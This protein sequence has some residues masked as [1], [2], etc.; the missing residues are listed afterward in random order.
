MVKASSGLLYTLT[1][2]GKIICMLASACLLLRASH[3]QECTFEV[4]PVFMKWSP[5]CAC[6]SKSLLRPPPP[7]LPSD[8]SRMRA[9]Q[10]FGEPVVIGRVEYFGLRI[11]RGNTIPRRPT[12]R[13]P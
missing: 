2:K 3:P 1:C 8:S 6:S 10:F 12:P 9:V 11:D 13:A 5:F 4:P 7:Q